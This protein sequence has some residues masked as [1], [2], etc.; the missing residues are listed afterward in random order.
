MSSLF[1]LA[2]TLEGQPDYIKMVLLNPDEELATVASVSSLSYR[3]IEYAS[4]DD[5][6]KDI[7]G[8]EITATASLTVGSTIYDTPIDD[9][10][11]FKMLSPGTNRPNGNKWIRHQ[12]TVTPTSGPAYMAVAYGYVIP[13]N[14]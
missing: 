6:I 8:T 13:V 5:A 3:V 2:D 12:I 10:Y 14:D 7:D 9:T 11:N 1:L 4:K